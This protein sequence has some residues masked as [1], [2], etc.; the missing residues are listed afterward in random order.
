MHGGGVNKQ[1]TGVQI[2]KLFQ[3]A[4]FVVL[5]K[6][7]HFPCQHLPHVERFDSFAI[8]CIVQLRKSKV[9]KHS[10]RVIAYFRNHLSPNSQW[11]EKNHDYYLWLRVSMG[12]ALTYLSTWC[13][14]PLLA[15]NMKVNPC[16]K[17]WQ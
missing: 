1:E 2:L 5:T 12:A 13:I 8:T 4:N 14:M 16:S 7:W 6:T 15:P 11:K 9:I 10:E 3:G 17:T